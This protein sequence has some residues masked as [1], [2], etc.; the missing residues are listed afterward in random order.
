MSIS[1]QSFMSVKVSALWKNVLEAHE[2][3][4]NRYYEVIMRN[5]FLNEKWHWLPQYMLYTSLRPR[6]L[7][8]EILI[9]NISNLG[10]YDSDYILEFSFIETWDVSLL[11]DQVRMIN[12]GYAHLLLNYASLDL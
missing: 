6:G 11:K 2:F 12:L 10:T 7:A 9:V 1:E 8:F 5:W 3:R 4:T